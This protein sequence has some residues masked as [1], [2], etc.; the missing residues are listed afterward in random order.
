M[1]W[2]NKQKNC[3]ISFKTSTKTHNVDWC[4]NNENIPWSTTKSQQCC[5]QKPTMSIG[6]STIKTFHRRLIKFSDVASCIKKSGRRLARLC[7][8]CTND[9]TIIN[10]I[11]IAE[12]VTG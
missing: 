5:A 1:M 8:N 12:S 10:G 2:C 4:N 3:F 9:V 6:A 11:C 7:N